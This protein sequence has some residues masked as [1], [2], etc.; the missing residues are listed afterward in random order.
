MND[1]LYNHPAWRE[2]GTGEPVNVDHVISEIVKSNYTSKSHDP[3]PVTE[4]ESTEE[5]RKDALKPDDFG[6]VGAKVDTSEHL[7]EPMNRESR[8][9]DHEEVNLMSGDVDTVVKQLN[10]TESTKQKAV[11]QTSADDEKVKL[12]EEDSEHKGQDHLDSNIETVEQIQER[13]VDKFDS[14]EHLPPAEVG[15][16]KETSSCDPDCTECRTVH[17]DPTPS[18]LMMYLHALSYKVWLWYLD[19]EKRYMYM[20]LDSHHLVLQFSTPFHS[21]YR[22]KGGSIARLCLSGLYQTGMKSDWIVSMKFSEITI[23]LHCI[24][25]HRIGCEQIMCSPSLSS[26]SLQTDTVVGSSGRF[27]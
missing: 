23:L 24:Q 8:T 12:L 16:E 3:T 26:V 13:F 1:P 5:E 25:C 9:T 2:G 22:V 15:T 7:L 21:V 19:L 4:A 27:F 18:E 10:D 6:Q 17:P 14:K 11:V 20:Y